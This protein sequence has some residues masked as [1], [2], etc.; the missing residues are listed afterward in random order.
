[1][2]VYI[3]TAGDYSDYRIEK[4]FTDKAKAEEFA[5][6]CYESNGVDEWDTEDDINVEKYYKICV[7]Y[8]VYDNGTTE[9]P[10]VAVYSCTNDN[11]GMNCTYLSDY[12]RYGGNYIVLNIHRLIKA[13]NRDKYFYKQKYTKVAYDTMAMIKQLV[14]DGYSYD[15]IDTMLKND[16][17]TQE[18]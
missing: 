4:V 1:M 16:A 9:N 7:Q 11:H 13:G 17:M 3:V 18:E 5:K 14:V 6:W 8:R 10:I 2:K 15:Q 12:H